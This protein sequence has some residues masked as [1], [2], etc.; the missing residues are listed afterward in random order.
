[1]AY[2]Y[3]EKEGMK[4]EEKRFEVGY[5][6]TGRYS[7]IVY[8]KTAMEAVENFNKCPEDYIDEFK[9]EEI[10]CR[11]ADISYEVDDDNCEIVGGENYEVGD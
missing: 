1:M 5:V 4:M 7:T 6:A 3:T 10:D 8:A 11:E 2:C 9:V